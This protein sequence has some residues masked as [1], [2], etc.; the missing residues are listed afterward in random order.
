MTEWSLS[1]SE[2]PGAVTGCPE[3]DHGAVAAVSQ[4]AFLAP[5]PVAGLP[6]A[7]GAHETAAAVAADLA[8]GAWLCLA[9]VPG[10][11]DRRLVGSVRS[12]VAPDGAWTVRRLAVDPRMHGKG[13]A[14]ALMRRLEQRAAAAGAPAVA[15]DAVVERGNPPFYARLGYRTVRHFPNPDKPLSETAMRRELAGSATPLDH[16]WDGED[17]AVAYGVLVVWHGNGNRTV[18]RTYTDVTDALSVLRRAEP[19][20]GLLGADGW[21]AGPAREAGPIRG[22]LAGCGG[23]VLDGGVIGY[24][25]P[26]GEVAAYRM[27][28]TVTP[29]LL[30]LW[31][32]P[33]RRAA[34]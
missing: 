34:R 1:M 29:E 27:P 28:R 20:L 16:P 6:I 5:E 30:A 3:V 2:D 22:R 21:A 26:H 18:A 15:L 12:F 24:D 11:G 31:R 32:L 19:G 17:A 14:K 9:H 25:R 10:D 8:A 33:R 7:D 13:L 23:S 4:A